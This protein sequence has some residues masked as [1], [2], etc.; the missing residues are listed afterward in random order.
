MGRPMALPAIPVNVST[1]QP[2]RSGC[3]VSSGGWMVDTRALLERINLAALIEADLGQPVRREGR[4]LKWTCPFHDDKETPSL[5]VANNHWKCFGC[6][7]SGDAVD[8][9]R[10]R[11]GLSFREACQQLGTREPLVVA[12]TTTGAGTASAPMPAA[13]WQERARK[14]VDA[15]QRALA[16]DVGARARTW[17]NRRG[18]AD[19]TIRV[20]RLGFNFP[21]RRGKGSR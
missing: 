2:G 7:R 11:E 10:Q 9:L 15:C 19:E 16:S 6:G 8:W 14:V 18:L 3:Q 12:T 4:W 13:A 1:R 17:L 20:W 5:G 21:G